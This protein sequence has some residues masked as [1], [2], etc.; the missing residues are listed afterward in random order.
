MGRRDAVAVGDQQTRP[1]V[2]RVRVEIDGA[3]RHATR[4]EDRLE[5][6]LETIDIDCGL[7]A[8]TVQQ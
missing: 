8:A 6:A 7:H 4:T 3:H 2:A 5:L 1:H